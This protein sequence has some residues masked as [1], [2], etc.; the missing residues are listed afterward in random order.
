VFKTSWA[1]YALGLAAVLAVLAL[2]PVGLAQTRRPAASPMDAAMRAYIEGRYDEVASLTDKLNA[3]DPAVAAL[4]AR[5][6]IERGRYQQA[7]AALRPIAGRAPTSDAALALGMLM[8]MLGRPDADQILTRVANADA[9]DPASMARSARAFRARGQ[10]QDFLDANELYREA[11]KA[12]PHDVA[13]NTAWGDLFLQRGQ[14]ND[15]LTSYKEVLADD[16]KWEP[17]IIGSARAIIDEDPPAAQKLAQQAL[18]INPSDVDAY[19][20][21]AGAQA[22]DADH[23][24]DAR[25][26][27]QKALDVNP[28][29]LGAHALLGAIA[30]VE[31]KKDEFQ[32][33][34]DTVF[35]IAP[36]YGEFYRVAASLTSRNYRFEEAAALARQGLAIDPDNADTLAEL[37]LDLL[38]TGDEDGARKALDTSWNLDHSSVVT[39]NLL[40]MMD[41]LD[42]F[43]TVHDGDVTL[44]INRDEAPVMQ[45]E[46]VALAHRALEALSKRYDFTPKGPFLVEIF[47]EHPDFAVRTAGLPGM[48]GAL[49]ACFGRVVTMESPHAE[50][51]F[52]FQWQA[53][54]WHE[55]AHVITLQMSEQRIPRWLT[56][57][58]SVYEQRIARPEWAR[59]QDLDFAG[60]M[61]EKGAIK[62]TELNDAFQNPELISIAYFEGSLLVDHIV[63][64]FG[65]EGLHKLVRAYARGVDTNAALKSELNTSFA[66]MQTGFDAYLERRFGAASRALAPPK[67]KVAILDMELPELKKYAESHEGAFAPQMVLAA[68]LHSAGNVDEA[69]QVYEKAAALMPMAIGP[70]SPHAKMAD[71]AVEQKNRPRAIAE[72]RTLLTVDLDN[73]KAARQLASLMKDENITDPAALRPV[74]ER[75]VALDPFEG[76]PHTMLGRMAIARNDAEA[77]SQ[78]FKIVLALKPVDLAGA[79]TD[80]ADALLRSGKR[81]EARKETLA[82][83]EIAPSY[84]RAQDLLLRLTENRH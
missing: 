42:K 48:F 43:V 45:D 9:R 80:Y 84:E 12:A 3:Q 34:A 75:I 32:A 81:P 17:A 22:V 7:E 73:L 83:L 30:Y 29:S 47:S 39:K 46:A 59:A 21:V 28:S 38:R 11:V 13:I 62:L 36:H 74:Y 49:G 52:N 15:A 26:M 18:Q 14:N 10:G 20:F 63:Q 37:G 25:K 23:R 33:Q 51:T 6:D 61:A 57:G 24:A 5:A 78:E 53:V 67:E 2:I 76:E 55:L 50:S 40:D 44:R 58:I 41:R 77:A 1:R 71:I 64:T 27:L 82:A 35:A 72:L 19:V 54:L 60:F 4:R 16:P 79:H 56:E 70:E 8:K 66:E 69:M 31:D 68:K 65:D